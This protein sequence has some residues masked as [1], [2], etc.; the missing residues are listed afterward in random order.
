MT[1]SRGTSLVQDLTGTI[2]VPNLDVGV[3]VTA[4]ARIGRGNVHSRRSARQSHLW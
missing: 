2:A 1:W 3:N 4:G